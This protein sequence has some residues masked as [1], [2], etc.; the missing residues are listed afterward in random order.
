MKKTMKKVDILEILDRIIPDREKNQ[1]ILDRVRPTQQD[2]EDFPLRL[3]GVTT[4]ATP[5]DLARFEQ[6]YERMAE[7]GQCD[8]FGCTES[9]R[10]WEEWLTCGMPADLTGFV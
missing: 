4:K 6:R 7:K 2:E 3:D 9:T 5:A 8:S 1:D 10:V